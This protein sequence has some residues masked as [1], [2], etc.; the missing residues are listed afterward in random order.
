MLRPRNPNSAAF[1]YPMQP[2]SLFLHSLLIAV[3]EVKYDF[4]VDKQVMVAYE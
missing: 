2:L 1:H 4:V 3:D